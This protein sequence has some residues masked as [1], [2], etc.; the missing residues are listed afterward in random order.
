MGYV[1]YSQNDPRWS[2]LHLGTSS[3]TMGQAG[4]YVTSM[5]VVASNL[6]HNVTPAQMLSLLE[7][8]GCINGSGDI[9]NPSA[10]CTVF[11]DIQ[12]VSSHTWPTVKADLSVI[13]E[14]T[15]IEIDDSPSA[16]M[17]THF[18]PVIKVVGT[19][20]KVMD[21]WDGVTRN[22]S[23]Y[24]AR[25]NPP[26]SAG[27]IIYGA[28]KYALAAAPKPVVNPN[29]TLAQLTQLY[30]DLLHRAPDQDGINHYVGHYTYAFVEQDIK[31]S[32]EY[33]A[34][35]AK[36]VPSEPTKPST[37]PVV[38]PPP[39]KPPETPADPVPVTKTPPVT[40]ITVTP[41]ETLWERFIAW[42]VKILGIK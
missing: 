26:V 31:N 12:L 21:V 10:L 41:V 24:G 1:N 23:A 9:T 42:L 22:V 40:P 4:C 28:W 6:G 18:M 25:W 36:E 27:A 7:Q 34:I 2:G 8:H 33:K 20:V 13:E 38:A 17:Q 35:Q 29:I 11:P 37:P 16:G 39:T 15:I 19:D 14:N 3:W 5:A 30:R 32:A